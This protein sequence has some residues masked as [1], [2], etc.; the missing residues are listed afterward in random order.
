LLDGVKLDIACRIDLLVEDLAIVQLKSVDAFA[1]VHQAQIISY[2][3][4][5]GRSLGLLINFN[6]PHLK[7]GIK[8]IRERYWLEVGAFTTKGIY[9]GHKGRAKPE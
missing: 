5:S 9:E 8:R 7:D 6:V 1:T 3:K 4:L 2:L